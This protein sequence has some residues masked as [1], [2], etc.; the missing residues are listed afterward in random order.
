M[1]EVRKLAVL[2]A[3]IIGLSAATLDYSASAASRC[4]VPVIAHADGSIEFDGARASDNAKL[5][6]LLTQYHKQNPKCEIRISADQIVSFQAVGR[7]IFAAQKAGFLKI[8]F[9]TEPDSP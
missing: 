4:F 3:V 6:A 1:S 2:G 5:A 8:G 9:L 7:I